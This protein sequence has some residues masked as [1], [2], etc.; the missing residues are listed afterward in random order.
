[1]YLD[2]IVIYGVDPQLVWCHA[3]IA[4]ERLVHAGFMVN[5]K[6]SELL[7]SG[8]KMLGFWVTKGKRLP[9]CP[10]LRAWVEGARIPRTKS[11]VQ[12]L[13]GLL[14]YFRS[15]IPNFAE[16]ASPI[17]RLMKNDREL[18]WTPR[19]TAIVEKVLSALTSHA[20]L[21]IPDPTRAFVLEVACTREGYGGILLQGQDGSKHLAPVGCV[22]TTKKR[23]S[24]SEVEGVLGAVLYCV[25]KF[26]EVLS[27]A[28]DIEV[29]V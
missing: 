7:T 25:R 3:K 9:C 20:G 10:Q 14:S 24:H 19:E 22:S 16:L 17:S 5:L 26:A 6:K 1:M 27:V 28:P 23:V 13:Y 8:I 18:R 11:D 4:L 15:F 12:A 21:V 2:D 29:R